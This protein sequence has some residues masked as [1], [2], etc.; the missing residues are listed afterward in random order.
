MKAAAL[1]HR[2]T[3]QLNVWAKALGKPDVQILSDADY[4][5][6]VSRG[7]VNY[8][9]ARS[10]KSIRIR[11]GTSSSYYIGVEDAAPAVPGISAPLR[12]ICIAPFGMEE[13]TEL[14]LE[15]KEFSLVVGELATFRFFS[16]STEQLHDG[17]TPVIGTIVRRW[18]QELTELHP[19]ETLLERG[20]DDGKTIQVKIRTRVT[21]L[22]VLEVWCDAADGRKWKLEFD[23]RKDAVVPA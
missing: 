15:D 3:E 20:V 21:E 17:T 13:G 16:H 7:A 22:G 12:A 9:L 18:K 10:G 5:F 4:D 2:L 8:G 19:I 23:I 14:K 11:S 1:R 6:G